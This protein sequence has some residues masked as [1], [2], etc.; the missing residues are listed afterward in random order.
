MSQGVAR[1]LVGDRRR[2]LRA[3]ASTLGVAALFAASFAFT[4]S[5][6][7]AP[8]VDA[9]AGCRIYVASGDDIPGGH[10]LNDDSKRYP[11]QLLEDHLISPGW[12]VYNQGTN[13]ETS[14]D[15]ITGGGLA[16]AYNQRPDLYT[17][18]LGEQNTPMVDT[19]TK[20]FDKIKDHDFSGGN[21][22]ASNVLSNQSLWTDL[23]KNYTTILS[24]TKIMASQRPGLVIAVVNYPNPYPQANDVI[25]KIQELCPKVIDSWFACLGRWMQLPP[26]LT[27]ID[28]VFKKLNK[29]LQDAMSP[30]QQ[31][32]NGWRWVYVDAYTPFLGHEMKME[33]T[34]KD[35]DVCHLC[36]TDY[37]YHDQHQGTKNI[38]SDEP[39][40]IE[41]SDGTKEP[42]YLKTP[43][44]LIAPPV[45]IQRVSQ[46]TKGMGVWVNADGHQCIADAIW[47]ADTIYPGTTPLKWLLGYGEP[48]NSDI[49][50]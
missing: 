12:C 22:C 36:H 28:K 42:D 5:P 10:D 17:I 23:T 31:G 24:M 8:T 34:L 26:A 32:P 37:E 33:V 1:M 27:T 47:E 50:Q 13:G 46:T 48:S 45:E 41:G 18:Q 29:T 44:P 4:L 6:A 35:D 43:G 7:G 39:W 16:K 20:C 11:E 25:P 2:G 19:I 49:C 9:A 15:F 38:G 14:S 40:F 3:R 21:S 30:F